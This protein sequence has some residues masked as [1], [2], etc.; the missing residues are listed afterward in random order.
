MGPSECHEQVT[1][2]IYE[3]IEEDGLNPLD[4]F[5]KA[6]LKCI[7]AIARRGARFWEGEDE[8]NYET[9]RKFLNRALDRKD[10][11][12]RRCKGDDGRCL[13]QQAKGFHRELDDWGLNPLD[14]FKP[15]TLFLLEQVTRKHAAIWEDEDRKSFRI[16][17]NWLWGALERHAE[18]R[19]NCDG[20]N[21]LMEQL[22]ELRD[23]IRAGVS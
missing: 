13:D 16:F 20:E 2:R 8:K 1:G 19:S 15:E 17:R 3:S 9:F 11:H 12:D 21:D 4:L 6:T 22:A 23:D 7:L 14:L 18:E 5:K 10:E